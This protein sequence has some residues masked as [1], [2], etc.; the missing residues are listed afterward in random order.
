VASPIEVAEFMVK[1]LNETKYLY[2]EDIVYQI[3]SQFGGEFVY[4]NQ[5]GNPAISPSVLKEFRK[6]T[7]GSVVWSRGERLWRKR[8]HYDDPTKRRAD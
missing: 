3:Q 1:R 7:E 8:E 5:N 4:D 6:L 2:Q